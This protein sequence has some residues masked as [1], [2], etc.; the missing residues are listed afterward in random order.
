MDLGAAALVLDVV[1]QS[2]DEEDSAAMVGEEIVGVKRVGNPREVE[3]FA[4]IAN[5][6]QH[7]V[8]VFA[9]DAARDHLLRIVAR[10]VCDGVSKGLAQYQI[11]LVFV[12]AG[13]LHRVHDF[14]YT[15]D[16]FG[17]M[18]HISGKLDVQAKLQQVAIEINLGTR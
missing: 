9:A 15:V 8:F 3:T 5:D 2:V 17:K 12:P 14:H 13:A 6:D 1:H 18:L 10:A 16:H 4:G 7:A 11:H